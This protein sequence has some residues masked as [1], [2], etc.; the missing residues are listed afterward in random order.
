[1]TMLKYRDY[2]TDADTISV[3]LSFVFAL[4]LVAYITYVVFFSIFRA[5]Q[6]QVL[7][8]AKI[9]ERQKSLKEKV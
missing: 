6:L 3:I 4:I 9:I 5:R 8:S 2:F 1:M 7:N